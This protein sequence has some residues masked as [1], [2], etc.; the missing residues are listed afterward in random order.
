MDMNY[1]K[2]FF[3]AV[4]AIEKKNY[5]VAQDLIDQSRWVKY[6]EK[7]DQSASDQQ[8]LEP[9]LSRILSVVTWKCS[10]QF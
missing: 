1:Q 9:E 2:N 10:L 5:V 3:S 4:S 7:S 6:S 8:V